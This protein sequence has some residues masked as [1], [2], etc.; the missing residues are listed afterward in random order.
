MSAWL[1]AMPV[2]PLDP[3][4]AGL[5]LLV[6]GRDPAMFLWPT[7]NSLDV[8]LVYVLDGRPTM[9]PASLESLRVDLGTANGFGYALRWYVRQVHPT[10]RSL[11]FVGGALT[12]V[13]LMILRHMV[14]TTTD[15][16]RFDL[17]QKCRGVA[18]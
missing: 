3:T 12:W 15:A 4:E 8:V 5:R 10:G 11:F 7:S 13:T 18:P 14:G 16:D 9:T 17:A 2:I 1:D 6:D